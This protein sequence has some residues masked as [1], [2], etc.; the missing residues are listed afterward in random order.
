MDEPVCRAGKETCREWTC[1]HAEGRGE[2]GESGDWDGHM[3]TTMCEIAS[4]WEAAV[5]GIGSSAWCS[6]VW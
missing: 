3:Y 6:V 2:W 5:C 1:R 4:W